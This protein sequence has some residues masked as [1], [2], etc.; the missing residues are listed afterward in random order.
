LFGNK[1]VKPYRYLWVIFVMIGSV[2]SLNIVWTFA[3]VTNALMA[4]PNLVSLLLLSG[5][6]VKETKKYLWDGNIEE[7]GN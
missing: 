1:V 3:D 7:E 2:V 4:L 6:I 5:V